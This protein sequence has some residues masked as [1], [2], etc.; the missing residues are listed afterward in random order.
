MERKQ[1]DGFV[2]CW[3]RV[4]SHGGSHNRA[5]VFIQDISSSSSSF[6]E[7]RSHPHL[8]PWFNVPQRVYKYGD[9]QR[10]FK[11]ADPIPF[12]VD[13]LPGIN[14]GNALRKKFKGLDGRDNP[15]FQNAAGAISCRFLV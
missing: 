15:M 9:K 3:S 4:A 2:W 7:Y 5:G 8:K 14:M 10:N 12:S 6:Y 1:W 13:G 11:K